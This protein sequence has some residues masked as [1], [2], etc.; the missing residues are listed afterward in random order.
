MGTAHKPYAGVLLGESLRTGAVLEGLSLVVTG[1]H[2][3]AA[4]DTTAG[5]PRLWT[6][7]EF[8]L[9]EEQTVE[10]ADKLS[11]VLSQEGGW[12]CDFR[13]DEEVFV[14]FSGR[15]FRYRRGDSFERTKAEDYGRSIG[16]P[17]AQLDWPD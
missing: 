13:S 14:V 3:T 2:R 17:E 15:V 5:Q 6:F 8:E 7:I 4:G 9:A 10:L 16:V 12:Y 1:V 11:R